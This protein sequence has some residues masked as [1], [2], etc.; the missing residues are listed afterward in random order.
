MIQIPQ[1]FLENLRTVSDSNIFNEVLQKISNHLFLSFSSDGIFDTFFKTG[2][3]K[4]ESILNSIQCNNVSKTFIRLNILK[5]LH[6][7]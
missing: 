6:R 2:V 4:F 1:I 5:A 7:K 3:N